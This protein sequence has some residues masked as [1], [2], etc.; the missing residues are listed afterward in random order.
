M[1]TPSQ[2]SCGSTLH[3]L[4][5]KTHVQVQFKLNK[6]EEMIDLNLP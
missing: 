1:V 2:K 3:K 4:K 5:L 6:I